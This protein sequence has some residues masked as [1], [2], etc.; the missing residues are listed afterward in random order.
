MN[1]NIMETVEIFKEIV[2]EIDL[3]DIPIRYIM[4]ATY[5]DRNGREIVI[6]DK[7]E[8]NS[9]LNREGDFDEEN[10]DRVNFILDMRVLAID[11]TIEVMNIFEKIQP[12]TDTE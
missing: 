11:V 12:N 5:R 7:S 2:S 1:N 6:S 10:L 9:L 8:I 4:A 3:A